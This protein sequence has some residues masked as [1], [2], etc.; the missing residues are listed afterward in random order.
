[1]PADV[2]NYPIHSQ[3]LSNGMRVLVS[4][5][6]SV[7]IVAVNLWYDVGSRDER[8][9]E[10]GW[11][12]LFEHLMFSGSAHVASGEHLQ[13]LQ[14][15]GGSV[16]A[17]T[18]FDRTNYFDT[19]PVGALDLALWLEADRL[20][21]LADHL[22]T[23][24]VDTQ[25]DV[26]KEE[27]RQRYDNVPYGDVMPALV[28]LVFGADHPYG[29]TTIGSMADL[30]AATPASAADFFRTHYRPDNAVLTLVGDINVRDGFRR[31]ERA[32]GHLPGRNRRRRPAPKT[33]PPLTGLPR[34]TLS[35]KVPAE[36][37]YLAWRLPARD[38]ASFDAADLALAVLGA[39]QTSRLHQRLVKER[40]LVASTAA[41][42]LPLIG[43]NSIGLLQLRALPLRAVSDG[44]EATLEQV[45]K[46]AAEG[47]TEAELA[48]AKAQFTREW[49]TDLSRFDARADLI[50][51]YAMLHDDPARVNRRLDEASQI[52]ADQ[53]Q[54]ATA[55]LLAPEARAQLDYHVE[56]D[57]ATS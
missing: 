15:L 35:G 27:K 28:A 11:A 8:A 56:D 36:V 7:P 57:N 41:Q 32:F 9:G 4:P 26:V 37:S 14:S 13:L 21:T 52:T 40:R 55:E 20:G 45:A 34:H 51:T 44:I 31:A 16:N 1:M 29:H 53:V 18:W 3:L 12:H 22:S 10:H 38:T 39:G 48:R 23:E 17:T 5:D 42:A 54:A 50:S 6:K 19:V 46:L 49:L 33:L 30:D 2:A 43:G 24:A 25:R 47:P